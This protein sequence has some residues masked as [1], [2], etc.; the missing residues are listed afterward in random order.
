V[1]CF[2]NDVTQLGSG[3][4][5]DIGLT[6][7]P[8][9]PRTSANLDKFIV[10]NFGLIE[11]GKT[12]ENHSEN[13]QFRGRNRDLVSHNCLRHFNGVK[14]PNYTIKLSMQGRSSCFNGSRWSW[15]SLKN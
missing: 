9:E 15:E 2:R 4:V 6:L 12:V 3:Y 1:S 14:Q 8:Y 10:T 5:T 11:L 13:L 7:D